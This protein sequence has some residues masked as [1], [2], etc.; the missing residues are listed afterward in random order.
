MEQ[1]ILRNTHA[2]YQRG[3][4]AAENVENKPRLVAMLGEFRRLRRLLRNARCKAR[5]SESGC[6]KRA[7][8]MT[9]EEA[10]RGYSPFPTFW[11]NQHEPSDFEF[12]TAKMRIELEAMRLFKELK[13]RKV[14][15]K[16]ILAVLGIAKGTRITEAYAHHF[17]ENLRIRQESSST[18]V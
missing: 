13:Y 7:R 15:C 1:A 11:C 10:D 18:D 12:L 17:C 5:C 9:F 2:V 14:F 16:Q 3:E 6:E 8:W 4:W